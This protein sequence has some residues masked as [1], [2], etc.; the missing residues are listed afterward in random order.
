MFINY[1]LWMT[2]TYFMARSRKVAHAF[3]WGKLV[4]V[5]MSFERKNL[6]KMGKWTNDM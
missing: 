5:K 6:L 1:D 2:F 4:I 3:E